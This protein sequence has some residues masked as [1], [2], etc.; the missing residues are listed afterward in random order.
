MLLSK[1]SDSFKFPRSSQIK[2]SYQKHIQSPEEPKNL[3]EIYA[4]KITDRGPRAK[5]HDLL[6]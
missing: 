2:V 1:S 5:N 3:F 6:E 4:Q